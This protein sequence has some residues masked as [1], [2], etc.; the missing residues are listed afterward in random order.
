ML[1]YKHFILCVVE[2]QTLSTTLYIIIVHNKYHNV[3]IDNLEKPQCVIIPCTEAGNKK[4][5]QNTQDITEQTRGYIPMD[6]VDVIK[7][8]RVKPTFT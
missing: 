3:A 7:H 4:K 8:R 5:R 2:D 6:C 1:F